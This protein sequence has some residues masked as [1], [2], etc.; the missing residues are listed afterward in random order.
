MLIEPFKEWIDCKQLSMRAGVELSY[1]SETAQ[2]AISEKHRRTD[3]TMVQ[4]DEK[5]AKRYRNLF[6]GFN[7][8][9]KQA[10]DLLHRESVSVT[11]KVVMT[12][13]KPIKISMQPNMFRKYFTA[14]T[15][16][17]EIADTIEKALEMYFAN[18]S[19]SDNEDKEIETL[20]LSVYTYNIL[21]RQRIDTVSELKKLM[22]DVSTA[23][24][25]LGRKIVAEIKEK[26]DG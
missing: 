24:N 1:I 12:S 4:I 10:A 8:T 23:E 21:K 13:E 2:T 5:T 7:G 6:E 19:G 14:D 20:D 22:S 9:E 18:T 15:K 3:G 16:P 25:I 17:Q 26:L 11:E